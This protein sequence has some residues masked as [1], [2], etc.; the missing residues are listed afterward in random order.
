MSQPNQ[1]LQSTPFP[2]SASLAN[3]DGTMPELPPH[4][5]SVRS[6]TANE[7]V[8]MMNRTPLF[9][10]SLDNAENEGAL[11]WMTL[12]PGMRLSKYE[13]EKQ[14]MSSSKH[15]ER[16]NTK[17]RLLKSHRVSKSKEMR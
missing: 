1:P 17:A 14:T 9:M 11:S 5:A 10:T 12:L 6:H 7:I 4:M 8:E 13:D 15:Y 16:Y 2:I 3:Q